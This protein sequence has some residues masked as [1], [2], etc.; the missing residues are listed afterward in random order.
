MRVSAIDHLVMTCSDVDRTVHW[1]SRVL[2]LDV[3]T[4]GPGRR[5][6]RVG[7]QKINLRPAASHDWVTGATSSP[8]DQ[9]L[10][11]LTELAPRQVLQRLDELGVEVTEGPVV[12][13]GARGPLTSVYCLDPDGSLVEIASYA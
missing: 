7:D 5:A 6:L 3:I 13:S 9:D 12:R 10:C 11:F 8:G 4:Y 1:Y 2:G